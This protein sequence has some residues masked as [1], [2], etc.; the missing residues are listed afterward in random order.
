[1]DRLAFN[2]SAFINEGR[3]ARQMTMNELSNVSTPGFKRSFE[4]VSYTHLR[5]HET[6]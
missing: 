6:G 5:A 1:M 3:V 2:A 4:A